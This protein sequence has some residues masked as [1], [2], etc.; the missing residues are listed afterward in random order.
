MKKYF[1]RLFKRMRALKTLVF[2]IRRPPRE[3]D[4]SAWTAPRGPWR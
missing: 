4:G 3:G 1:G 2:F